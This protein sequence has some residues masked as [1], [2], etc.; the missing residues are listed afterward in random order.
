M[1][2]YTRA[3]KEAEIERFKG[4]LAKL[5]HDIEYSIGSRSMKMREIREIE[6]HLEWLE[7]LAVK[8]DEDMGCGRVQIF[9]GV[10]R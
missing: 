4:V 7:K 2:I 10:P 3:E 5:N 6:Q 1:A 8:E 9:A